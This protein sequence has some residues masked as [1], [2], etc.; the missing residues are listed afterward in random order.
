MN[1]EQ[2]TEPIIE[3]IDFTRPDFTFSPNETHDWKQKGPY[4]IC[5]SCEIMHATF[6][7]INK[8][9]VG[10]D[11]KGKPILKKR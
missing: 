9:L 1:N 11:K 5:K 3:Q 7:G 6:I 10:L 8:I 2:E 4:L